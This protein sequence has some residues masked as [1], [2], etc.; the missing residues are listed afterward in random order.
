MQTPDIHTKQAVCTHSLYD[1]LG[2]K[3]EGNRC[4]DEKYT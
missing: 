1:Q 2:L 4:K 3:K